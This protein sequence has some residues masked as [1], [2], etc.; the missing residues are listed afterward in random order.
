[1]SRRATQRP[2]GLFR[3]AVMSYLG[4]QR[5]SSGPRDMVRFA[6]QS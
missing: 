5:L 2:Q 4:H 1:M 6:P 3:E